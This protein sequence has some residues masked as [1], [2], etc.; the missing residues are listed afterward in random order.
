MPMRPCSSAIMYPTPWNRPDSYAMKASPKVQRVFGSD[1]VAVVTLP[2]SASAP[3]FLSHFPGLFFFGLM[4]AGYHATSAV[5]SRGMAS[6]TTGSQEG[7]A[8]TFIGG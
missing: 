2:S 3:G 8:M 1:Q 7:G 5:I 6:G 4:M